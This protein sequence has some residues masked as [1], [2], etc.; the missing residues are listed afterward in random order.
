MEGYELPA[1]PVE[2]KRSR[3]GD[4][5]D[6]RKNATLGSIYP[7]SMEPPLELPRLMVFLREPNVELDTHGNPA[8]LQVLGLAESRNRIVKN[9]IAVSKPKPHK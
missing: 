9:E 4:W 3:D 1:K 7:Q 5:S 6:C 2:E 8:R